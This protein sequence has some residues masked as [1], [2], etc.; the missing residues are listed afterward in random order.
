[1]QPDP[2]TGLYPRGTKLADVPPSFCGRPLKW[3]EE[4]ATAKTFADAHRLDKPRT[5][6]EAAQWERRH[7]IATKRDSYGWR[8]L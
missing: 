7:P 4:Y 5:E 2:I 3:W 6:Q 1:M 8:S